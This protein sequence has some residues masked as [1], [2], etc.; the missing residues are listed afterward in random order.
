MKQK[1]FKQKMTKQEQKERSD[2]GQATKGKKTQ[3][4]QPTH[5]NKY[6]LNTRTAHGKQEQFQNLIGGYI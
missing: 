2:P 1:G 6:Y 4:N 3:T 5:T